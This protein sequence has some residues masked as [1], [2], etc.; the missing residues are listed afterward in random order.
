MARV[1][2]DYYAAK[3]DAEKPDPLDDPAV[4]RRFHPRYPYQWQSIL[5]TTEARY[6]RSKTMLAVAEVLH[7]GAQKYAWESWR[8]VPDGI[9]R[10]QSSCLRHLLRETY[11]PDDGEL[12]AESGLPHWAHAAASAVIVLELMAAQGSE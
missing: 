6:G 10:Y 3:F 2:E 1:T 8:E 12:D 7:Y 4:R 9:R 5:S 11:Y